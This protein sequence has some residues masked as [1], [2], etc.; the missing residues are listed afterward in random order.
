VVPAPATSQAVTTGASPRAA[1]WCGIVA[2]VGLAIESAL[3]TASGWDADTFD[4]PAAAL[5][6]LADDGTVLRWA[7]FAGFVN[8]VFLV[9][10]TSGLAGRLRAKTATLASATLWFGMIGITTHVLVP[11]AHWFGVPAFLQAAERDPHAAE[12]AWTAFV[13]VGHDAAGGAGAL[14]LGLSMLAVGWA[15]ISAEDLS[16]RLGWLALLAGA[17]TVLTLFEPET[18]LSGPAESLFAPSLTLAILFRIWA[19][20]TLIRLEGRARFI[21]AGR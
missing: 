15:A 16:V 4:D 8:L 2:G 13:T 14:F 11:M 6:F 17:A 5:R 18:P 21:R 1:G 3:W 7:V 20:I 12:A 19:G 9:V 10:F